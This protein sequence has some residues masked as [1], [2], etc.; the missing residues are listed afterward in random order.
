[1]P[2]IFLIKPQ[3][4]M[5]NSFNISVKPEIAAV[6]TVV[7]A[8]SVILVDV[9]NTDL[10]AAKT[11]IDE[12]KVILVDVHDTDLPAAKTVIDSNA[13]NIGHIRNTAIPNVIT[14]IDANETKIDDNKAILDLIQAKTDTIPQKFRGHFTLTALNTTSASWVDVINIT[15]QGTLIGLCILCNY[16]DDT[17]EAS[18]LIDGVASVTVT[19]TG[20]TIPQVLVPAQHYAETYNFVKLTDPVGQLT[21][22]NV[23]FDTNLRVYLK[24]SAG[25]SGIVSCGVQYSVLSV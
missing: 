19:H 9:H 17:V 13:S 18:V 5:S 11:V 2:S 22:F 4:T 21:S 10:P 8:N 24:R 16:A 1:L 12:N 14:E 25:T 6:K 15:G 3:P 7:D 23:E 20:D